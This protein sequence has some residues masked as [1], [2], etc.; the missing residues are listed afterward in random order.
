[1]TLNPVTSSLTNPEF[2]TCELSV[3]QTTLSQ[4]RYLAALGIWLRGWQEA[5]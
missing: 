5:S 1:M 3:T 4:A 2:E